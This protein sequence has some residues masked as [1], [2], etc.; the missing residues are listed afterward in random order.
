[1]KRSFLIYIFFTF[2]AFL[3]CGACSAKKDRQTDNENLHVLME[4]ESE[5]QSPE[6]MPLSDVTSRFQFAGKTY[7]AQV[8]RTADETLPKVKDEQG[9]EYVDNRIT[10]RITTQGHTT[11]ERIFAKQSFSSVVPDNF[12]QHAILEGLVYDT[13][14]AYGMVF[15]ASV[16]YPQSDLYIPIRL[17]L[18]IDGQVSMKTED[19]L[20][21]YEEPPI[22]M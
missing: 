22:S 5:Y 10:L 21:G 15:A 4:T 8:F 12:M 20:G 2:L 11:I 3:T 17:T 18:T 14:T 9:N 19:L 7:E 1:M 16:S 6:R 13:I